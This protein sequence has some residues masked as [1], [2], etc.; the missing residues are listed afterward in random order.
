M[1]MEQEHFGDVGDELN[2]IFTK[3]V[4]EILQNK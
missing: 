3:Y 1:L 4:F 2:T